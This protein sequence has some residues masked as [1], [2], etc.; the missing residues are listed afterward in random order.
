MIS[1][2]SAYYTVWHVILPTIVVVVDDDD[3]DTI[4]SKNRTFNKTDLNGT[5][6]L[7]SRRE[8]FDKLLNNCEFQFP[9]LQKW[10]NYS[11]MESC[12]CL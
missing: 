6:S 7:A 10:G 5:P 11:D 9:F 3:D 1:M 12:V 4:F 2:D 8:T